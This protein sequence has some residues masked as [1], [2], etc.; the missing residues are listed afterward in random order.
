MGVKFLCSIFGHKF[1][2][3]AP[4]IVRCRRC[5]FTRQGI[6]E[7]HPVSFEAN[8]PSTMKLKAWEK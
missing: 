6:T 3:V 7:A 2:T 4:G 5:G 1:K 8:T